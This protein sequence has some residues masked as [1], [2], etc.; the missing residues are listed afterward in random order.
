M[1]SRVARPGT[2]TAPQSSPFFRSACAA[3]CA[4]RRLSAMN[5]LSGAI[6]YIKGSEAPPSA[7]IPRLVDR[8]AASSLPR[9]RREAVAALAAAAAE[10]PAAQA[11]VG[12][13]ALKVVYAVLEQDKD[14]DE[15]V[16][17]VLDLLITLC[18]VLDAPGPGGDGGERGERE[19][20]EAMEEEEKKLW[21]RASADAAATN[22]DA[23]LGL[24]NA[25][26]MVLE[27]LD[28]G[29]LFLRCS[30][31]ELL[32][33][34]S[35]NSRETVQ[36]AVLAS[37]EA[38]ARLSDLLDDQ[39]SIVRTNAT[40][41][42]SLLAENSAEICKIV[43]FSG[44]LETLFRL[45]SLASAGSGAIVPGADQG[46]LARD[47]LAALTDDPDPE[48]AIAVSY[49]LELV[50]NLLL[51]SSVTQSFLRDTGCIPR[52]SQVL[53]HAATRSGAFNPAPLAGLVGP[54]RS[55]ALQNHA[56]VVLGLE[57]V[58]LLVV[59]STPDA[60]RNRTVCAGA[61]IVRTVLQLCFAMPQRSPGMERDRDELRIHAMLCA[62]ELVSGHEEVRGMFCAPMSALGGPS[63]SRPPQ[64]VAVEVV[65]SDPSAAVRAAANT[66]LTASLLADTA[67]KLPATALLNALVAD[68][69]GALA[70]VSTGNAQGGLS[71]SSSVGS[72]AAVLKANLIG[73]PNDADGAGVFYAS[74]DIA[75]VC[76]RL[77][78]ARERLLGA[79]VS[80]SGDVLLSR[81]VRCLGQAFREEGPPA[82][83][84]G[85]LKLICTWLYSS[86]SAVS[87]FLSSAMHLPLIVE[88]VSK[89]PSRGDMAVSA[90]TQGLAALVLGVCL[91]TV[92]WESSSSVTDGGFISG[93]GGASTVV[94]RSTLVDIV[95]NRIGVSTFTARLDEL[96]A[97]RA[98]IAAAK[99]ELGNAQPLQ[100]LKKGGEAE[101]NRGD[102]GHELW[103]DTEF[104]TLTDDVYGKVSSRVLELVAEEQP[105]VSLNG[106]GVA[107]G[108]P[109][110]Y[111][112]GS[113]AAVNDIGDRAGPHRDGMSLMPTVTPSSMA[114]P[115]IES[116]SRDV[117]L[118]SYKELIRSQDVSLAKSRT[119]IGELEAALREAQLELDS[120]NRAGADG[121]SRT[122]REQL[123]VSNASL[124]ERANALEAMLQEKTEE[125]AALSEAYSALEAM[126]GAAEDE[127]VVAKR[128]ES[129][130]AEAERLR[131]EKAATLSQF[132]SECDKVTRLEALRSSLQLSEAK[133]QADL[134]AVEKER[135]ALRQ[136]GAGFGNALEGMDV[137]EWRRRAE[138]SESQVQ[139]LTNALK[140]SEDDSGE[141]R[142]ELRSLK[143]SSEDA[144]SQ[145]AS[146]AS[147]LE[148]AEAEVAQLHAL[149]K[150][151]AHMARESAMTADAAAK[152]EVSSLVGELE[153]LRSVQ[154]SAPQQNTSDGPVTDGPASQS[155]EQDT[156]LRDAEAASAELSDLRNSCA[157]WKER[158]SVAQSKA[159]NGEQMLLAEQKEARRLASVAREAQGELEALRA[160]TTPKLENLSTATRRV[161]ELEEQCADLEEM[162]VRN[163]DELE[164]LK[165]EVAS[166]AEQTIRLSGKVYEAEESR[167]DAEGKLEEALARLQ[168][169]EASS[170]LSRDESKLGGDSIGRRP[171]DDFDLSSGGGRSNEDQEYIAALSEEILSLKSKMSDMQ[172]T[173]DDSRDKE[174]LSAAIAKDRDEALQRLESME[175]ELATNQSSKTLM[176]AQLEK[177]EDRLLLLGEAEEAKR[178]LTARV[179]E[180]EQALSE[181]EASSSAPPTA[182]ST[183]TSAISGNSTLDSRSG[184]P[185]NALRTELDEKT[186]RIGELESSLKN[187]ADSGIA[188]GKSICELEKQLSE[189][190]ALL[191]VVSGEKSE[192]AA[193][194]AR[195]SAE[196]DCLRRDK[197]ELV[198][199]IN[200]LG[201]GNASPSDERASD[202]DIL[203]MQEELSV[204]QRRIETLERATADLETTKGHLGEKELELLSQQAEI[205][206]LAKTIDRLQNE[207]KGVEQDQRTKRE[208]LELDLQTAR[209]DLRSREDELHA[210]R[211]RGAAERAEELQ[212][213][214][215]ERDEALVELSA[216]G[217]AAKEA[218]EEIKELK[219]ALSDAAK[220]FKASA[221]ELVQREELLVEISRDKTSVTN[222]LE[223]ARETID[224]LHEDALK[225]ASAFADEKAKLIDQLVEAEKK[226]S[227]S[228][229]APDTRVAPLPVAPVANVVPIDAH[230]VSIVELGMTATLVDEVE[231]KIALL[232][233]KHTSLLEAAKEDKK[234]IS[235]LDAELVSER[236]CRNADVAS[237]ASLKAQLVTQTATHA[238]E[239]GGLRT[240]VELQAKELESKSAQVVSLEKDVEV[241]RGEVNILKASIEESRLE[242][243]KLVSARDSSEA[244]AV[245]LEEELSSVKVALVKHQEAQSSRIATLE[246]EALALKESHQ[247]VLDLKQADIDGLAASLAYARKEAEDAAQDYENRLDAI[248]KRVTELE[249][250]VDSGIESLE[251][252]ERSLRDAKA[253]AQAAEH[254]A[255]VAIDK[256]KGE[257]AH[258]EQVV[259]DKEQAID[260]ANESASRDKS[261][262]NKLLSAAKEDTAQ[263]KS[264]LGR[265]EKRAES[266]ERELKSVRGELVSAES[267]LSDAA[268]RIDKLNTKVG[269]ID[270]ECQRL[271]E[272][273][274]GLQANVGERDST[275]TDLRRHLQGSE[276][277]LAASTVSLKEEKETVASRDVELC[278]VTGEVDRLRLARGRLE[279]EVDTLH[280][281]V[282]TIE[283]AR[284]VLEKDN[285]DLRAWVKDL[286]REANG[287]QALAVKFEEVEASLDEAVAAHQSAMN[288][289][290]NLTTKVEALASDLEQAQSLEKTSRAE[291][292][293]AEAAAALARKQMEEV[294]VRL[295]EI[296]STH[297]SKLTATED[298]I[299]ANVAKT[300][301]LES[302]LATAERQ[303]AETAT[304]SD[305]IFAVQTELTRVQTEA[306]SYLARAESAEAE[307]D[308]ARREVNRMEK[309]VASVRTSSGGEAYAQLEAEHNELLM[310]LAE[311]EL[312]HTA[313]KDTVTH[314]RTTTIESV[315]A[316]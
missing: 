34:M 218:D 244:A 231:Q 151:E 250:E 75:W 184:T 59:E 242:R 227:S 38:V 264:K 142:A 79:H 182:G 194:V 57:C 208:V 178:M 191:S 198:A 70:N 52:M 170:A 221:K 7:A 243:E 139:T 174:G 292:D 32:T 69:G 77:R 121:A 278:K 94:P 37:P 228:A 298:R 50:R 72:V 129:H 199:K 166:R 26:S 294:D 96:R 3:R 236:D 138:A 119:Q 229:L 127:D 310:C 88:L 64:L 233:A 11:D 108:M 187:M 314:G 76:A 110:T 248:G 155:Q 130:R 307:A 113:P 132:Y 315:S 135:D 224:A 171:E 66:L 97:T 104:A 90:H 256:L 222:D 291:K 145:S 13:R 136:G 284:A 230:S 226:A 81:A 217:S 140:R 312:E 175:K 280:S 147:R 12:E 41:L 24:P 10:S 4:A 172:D 290:G 163:L 19:E 111:P 283:G 301:E 49:S 185:M 92:D 186:L 211:E 137:A 103:Y 267:R 201:D 47:A 240:Q 125:F 225:S 93:G 161:S 22:T 116:S 30:S 259:A 299:R 43:A 14:F 17:A 9:D 15:S 62:A 118:V 276:T 63:R 176:E 202:E 258:L 99:G 209:K 239:V 207:Q 148:K 45:L 196:V 23:F 308:N 173:L 302:A 74:C 122:Q 262:L 42:L 261:S 2:A 106:G 89:K 134:R 85:L 55:A 212:S 68:G 266:A 44:V 152:A 234:R 271:R 157:E 260:V 153:K 190:E 141:L 39:S 247:E 117:V 305:K 313:L 277:L 51:G 16:R 183:M 149:R 156:V 112:K 288:L 84:I 128:E 249:A 154:A 91:E 86:P 177:L 295:Q 48:S 180:L 206:S 126:G 203:A 268:T 216:L 5:Y 272:S 168:E 193:H 29:D 158:A 303:L 120:K 53:S 31:I 220:S 56:N 160:D 114:V 273:I 115:L 98:Y 169:L 251:S 297:A 197:S 210:T 78:G 238:S 235:S 282:D 263:V 270:G 306:A 213:I 293:I 189:S 8:I 95:R 253:A 21:E 309:E 200:A 162:R 192:H 179:G 109:P 254:K 311:M 58:R 205:D 316:R 289:N 65:T 204:A 181:A 83:R 36:G 82:V 20:R 304:L 73:W 241:I 255:T 101:V 215:R 143:S 35:V 146:A 219:V 105:S 102:L 275:I 237:G 300:A 100:L 195:L 133:L 164:R 80:G 87:A 27:V 60:D 269:D 67:L 107:P 25:M 1:S 124:S 286:E 33:A 214:A 131:Q 46:K 6:H 246:N 167:V 71:P 28:V 18:G 232:E 245:Q 159:D 296:R 279:E 252:A 40:L 265:S 281:E 54:A 150:R 61:G 223:R 285:A 274:S 123:E 165:E 287:L 144:L 257:K 188:A